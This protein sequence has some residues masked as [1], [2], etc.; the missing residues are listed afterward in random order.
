[1]PFACFL[2]R[3]KPRAHILSFDCI[4]TG[5]SVEGRWQLALAE[6]HGRLIVIVT[7]LGVAGGGEGDDA[8][9]AQCQPFRRSQRVRCCFADDRRIGFQDSSPTIV[10]SLGLFFEN[11]GLA[12]RFRIQDMD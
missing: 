11:T 4:T 8:K 5:I 3:F 12:V 2:Q 10:R 6:D 9:L 7:H 1:M